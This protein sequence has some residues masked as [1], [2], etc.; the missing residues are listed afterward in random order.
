MSLLNRGRRFFYLAGIAL[1]GCC[2]IIRGNFG[3]A[4]VT[5]TIEYLIVGKLK[6]A[7]AML[8]LFAT[9]FCCTGCFIAGLGTGKAKG[10]GACLK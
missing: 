10:L 1:L 4:K 7:T 6:M 2:V 3:H 5:H 8:E 9:C